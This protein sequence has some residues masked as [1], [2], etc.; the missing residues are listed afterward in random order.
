[1]AA[2]ETLEK[3]LIRYWMELQTLKTLDEWNAWL[4]NLGLS[5]SV[6]DSPNL[7]YGEK[8]N[9]Q[10]FLKL[11]EKELSAYPDW[12][13][14]FTSPIWLE[15]QHLVVIPDSSSP[16][17]ESQETPPKI[18]QILNQVRQL[19]QKVEILER[20]VERLSSR[21][22][23]SN[24]RRGYENTG[25]PRTQLPSKAPLPLPKTLILEKDSDSQQANQKKIGTKSKKTTKQ[26]SLE[27]TF[28]SF[29]EWCELFAQHQLDLQA[30]TPSS[31]AV[32]STRPISL[33]QFEHRIGRLI[34][35][36]D[37]LR[38]LFHEFKEL[39]PK[40]VLSNNLSSTKSIS[41]DSENETSYL[42][43]IRQEIKDSDL[44]EI[45]S[46]T[47][48]SENAVE[49]ESEGES[50]IA[51][52]VEF[53]PP[54]NSDY[55]AFNEWIAWLLEQGIDPKQFTKREIKNDSSRRISFV[56]FCRRLERQL[57]NVSGFQK[58]VTKN[59]T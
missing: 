50:T 42:E 41:S 45:K 14:K 59:N 53:Q 44:E 21:E 3:Q 18:N 11:C 17:S 27:E 7:V 56:Q 34:E 9:F 1:M 4:V 39:D 33:Q 23:F 12:Q 26:Q 5:I 47:G 35:D 25:N 19:Q 46:E 40:D 54:S 58:V 31:L 55:R 15:E 30:L 38:Q 8:I 24:S 43:E 51:S 22:R 48:D 29:N 16:W 13:K 36:Q 49:E 10:Q 2:V 37:A 57:D 52:V 32:P 28:L 20:H 6:D